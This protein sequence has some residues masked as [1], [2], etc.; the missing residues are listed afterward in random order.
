MPN[1]IDEFESMGADIG[2]AVSNAV[3]TGDYSHLSSDIQSL[4]GQT[5]DSVG[6][7]TRASQR[8]MRGGTQ[9]HYASQ[10]GVRQAAPDDNIISGKAREVFSQ[11]VY[12]PNGQPV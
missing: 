9:P 12:G 4:V 2:D 1:L 6:I 3:R 11:P 5:L 7:T 8:Q 10:R